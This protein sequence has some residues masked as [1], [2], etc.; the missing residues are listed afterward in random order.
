MRTDGV[1]NFEELEEKTDVEGNHVKFLQ[2]LLQ[3]AIERRYSIAF[4]RLPDQNNI[5]VIIDTEGFHELEEIDLEEL[6]KGFIFCPYDDTRGAQV[7]IRRHISFSTEKEILEFDQ[8]VSDEIRSVFSSLNSSVSDPEAGQKNIQYYSGEK[9][10]DSDTSKEDYFTTVDESVKAIK[11]S[12]FEK[13]VPSKVKCLVLDKGFDVVENFFKVSNAYPRSFVYFVSVPGIGSWMGASPETLIEI[14]DAKKFRTI[15]LAGTQ[16]LKP[17]I[18]PGSV[19]WTQKEIEEQAMVS[20]YIINCFKQIRLREFEEKGPKTVIAGKL[21][22][23]KTTFEVDMEETGFHNLGTVMLKLLHP[24]SAVC[25]MPREAANNFLMKVEKHDRKY[26]CGFLGPVDNSHDTH[27]YVNL[28]CMEL[29]EDEAILY[30]G[31]GITEDSDPEKE[32]Q[33]TEIKCN[34]LLDV[35]ASK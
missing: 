32:W 28:R 12:H 10:V 35:I 6:E 2:K 24:T 20:R 14:E 8:E 15:S 1:M 23:L 21:L 22:H 4:W 16:Q 19:A 18:S 7:F 30:A 9:D 33:E 17:D 11:A 3:I 5:Q 13:V 25:G 26:F 34:T 31:A 29:F 27:L